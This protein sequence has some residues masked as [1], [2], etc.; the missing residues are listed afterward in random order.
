MGAPKDLFYTKEHEWVRIEGTVATIGISDHA[1]SSLGDITFIELPQ[2]GKEVK[3]FGAL[4]NVESVKA[5]SDIYSPLSG[6][7]IEV[8]EALS[9][10]PDLINK[11]C[12]ADGWICK[13]EISDA[14]EKSGLMDPDAYE[15]FVKTLEH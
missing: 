4:A 7:V 13:F 10:S 2:A 14:G 6:K 1:Q 15:E 12:Y 3:Q 11:S 5:A 8:N 9:S